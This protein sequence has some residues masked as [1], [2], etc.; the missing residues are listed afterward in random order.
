VAK[1]KV[2]FIPSRHRDM[3]WA[4]VQYETTST[5]VA[6]IAV[7]IGMSATALISHASTHGWVRD[8][9][10]LVAKM[11]ADMILA[12]RIRAEEQREQRL[13]V[14]ERVNTE[15]QAEVLSTHRKDIKQARNVCREMFSQLSTEELDLDAKSRVMSRLADSLKTLVLLE[16]QAFGIQGVFED[17]DKPPPSPTEQGQVDAVM[18]KFAAVLAKKMGAVEVVNNDA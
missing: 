12:S 7:M 6:D 3:D 4:Q 1:D 13:E 10:K 8:K 11:T 16:R 9:G 5:P 2:V 18:S 14:I 15:M 17:T